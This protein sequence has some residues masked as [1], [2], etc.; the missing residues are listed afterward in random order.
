M[1]TTSVSKYTQPHPFDFPER[2][3]PSRSITTSPIW[4]S[5]DLRDGNQA[6][7]QPT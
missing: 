2:Q 5:V 7:A 4:V 1:I 6:L 3:W